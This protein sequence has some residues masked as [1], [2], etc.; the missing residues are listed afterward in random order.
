MDARGLP[1]STT[2]SQTHVPNSLYC[3]KVQPIAHAKM[4]VGLVRRTKK[5]HW[6]LSQRRMV[7]SLEM[8]GKTFHR[9]CFRSQTQDR[10][11]NLPTSALV[12]VMGHLR[13]YPPFHKSAQ[14][15][16]WRDPLEL[17]QMYTNHGVCLERREGF[18]PNPRRCID[19]IGQAGLDLTK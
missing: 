16:N 13:R 12:F 6:Q 15:W 3:P 2:Y 18:R 9:G 5:W 11:W 17:C 14:G 8:I 7:H 4:K 10:R 19:S 1:P